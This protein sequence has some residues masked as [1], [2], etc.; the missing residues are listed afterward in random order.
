M[1]TEVNRIFLH[2][3]LVK[4]LG[5]NTE[6]MKLALFQTEIIWEDP[7]A[8]FRAIENYI[9]QLEDGVDIIVLPE[10]FTTGFSMNV[11]KFADESGE[12]VTWMKKKALRKNCAISGTAMIKEGTDYFN[13]HYFVSAEGEI[14]HY[15]KR[16]LFR[17]SRERDFFKQGD[18]RVVI[19]V[20]GF[21]ILLQTCYDLRF[22]V[23]SRYKGDYDAILYAANW[24]AV[25]QL[26][27]TTLLRARA[28]ENQA[29]VIG[30]NRSG[31]VDGE[32]LEY[33]GESCMV[34]PLGK[35][36][37][38]MDESPGIR[39]VELNIDEVRSWRKRFPAS[40]DADSYIIDGLDIN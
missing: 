30:I 15:D 24:P 39:V 25:R 14:R 1:P 32:G 35:I 20:S 18:Q 33:S 21:R 13:R 3:Q 36:K 29:Y 10:T 6:N 28:I 9:D 22:P 23:F 4:E 38:K 17:M 26:V 8:N 11:K 7:I 12:T 5:F 19:E 27:W 37:E 2:W 34:D 40:E 31:G 16:H